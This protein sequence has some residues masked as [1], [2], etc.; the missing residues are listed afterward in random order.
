[1]TL[2]S[3]FVSDVLATAVDR[4]APA[5]R[6][7]REAMLA[8]LDR[9]DELTRRVVAGGGASDPDKAAAAVSRHRARGKLLPRER[10]AGLLDPGSPF[11]ELSPLA[12]YGSADEL[13]VGLVTGIGW[14][15]GVAVV[16]SA[17]D[18]TVRGG[19]QSPTTMVKQLRAMEVARVNRLPFVSLTESGGADLVNQADVFVPGGA[20]FRRLTQ[21]SAAGIPTVTLVFGSSTAGGAYVPGMS[22][23]VVMQRGA[24]RVYL[25]G[26]PLVRMA[27]NEEAVDEDL[28]G[29]QMHA[30]VSGLADHLAQDEA[31]ALRLG[32]Q[33]VAHL[34]WRPLGPSPR[35]TD[36]DPPVHDVEDLLGIAPSDVRRPFDVREVLARVVDGSRFAPFKPGYGSQLVTGWAEL[37]GYPIGVVANNG[38]LFGAEARKGA[39]FIQLC[40]RRD[41]PI[42]FV[43]NTTGFMVGTRA[44]QQGIVKDGALLINAVS[45]S[46]VPHVTLMVGASYGA[47][48][49][50]M[51]GRAF[52]PR[53]VFTWPNHRIAVMGPAQLAGVLRIIAQQKVEATGGRFDEEAYEPTRA[54]HQARVEQ[55]SEALYATGRVWDDGI[56]DPRD[57]RTVLGL[58]L[59][60]V[61]SAEVRGTSTFGVFRM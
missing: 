40:N 18:P 39:Q 14:V 34:G 36:P 46:T 26:P 12:G 60:A 16:V 33:V 42:L 35:T 59:A 13:G 45:N 1:M 6:A 56:I 19:A 43:Q 2:A 20:G 51:A 55:Q 53:F 3:G 11:L 31:D 29:A 54:A 50:G 5:F 22:D 21:L 10:I 28:G 44:E 27:I 4:S 23:H 38:I 61:H 17:N 15:S 47:G 57:T 32:R 8:A 58:A 9:I 24:A 41:T 48:N 30:Q 52:D 25:A 7:D 49:Y 37:A